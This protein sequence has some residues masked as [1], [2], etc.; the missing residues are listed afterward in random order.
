MESDKTET[1]TKL[2]TIKTHELSLR[3]NLENYAFFIWDGLKFF[4][5][6]FDKLPRL[7]G[8][9]KSF[10]D[11]LQNRKTIAS[12]IL[13][14]STATVSTSFS[15]KAFPSMIFVSMTTCNSPLINL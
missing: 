15:E 4:R 12:L 8:K 2:C 5:F 13:L 7:R 1:Q 3:K 10:T 14:A 6:D 9:K 11:K